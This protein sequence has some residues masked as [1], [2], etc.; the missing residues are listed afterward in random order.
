MSLNAY[1]VFKN[2]AIVGFASLAVYNGYNYVPFV[3]DSL[4]EAFVYPD[5]NVK[6]DPNVFHKLKLVS[7]QKL[8]HDTSS[9]HFVD[10]NPTNRLNRDRYAMSYVVTKSTEYVILINKY[11]KM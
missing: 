4:D 9:F 6:R 3:R 1:N 11:N 8:T 2:A 10:E 5:K 7:V